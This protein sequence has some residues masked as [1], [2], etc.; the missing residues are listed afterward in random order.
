[1]K[2]TSYLESSMTDI[3]PRQTT[4]LTIA[5]DGPAASGKT[6]VGMRLAQAIGAICLDTGVMYRAVT[7]AVLQAGVDPLDEKAVVKVARKTKISVALSHM[8]DGR[9]FDVLVDSVDV[10]EQLRTDEVNRFVSEVSAYKGVRS[11]MTR[12][13][14]RIAKAGNIVMLGRDIGT[15][16]L[17]HADLKIY[18]NASAE[19]RAQRRFEEEKLRGVILDLDQV[20]ASIK[21][22]DVID[23][24]RKYAPLKPA[25]DAII[26]N[27]DGL[28]VEPVVALM[29][30]EVNKTLQKKQETRD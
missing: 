24:S 27:T 26:I 11:A 20:I 23:S 7:L 5:I 1:L 22:R 14:Q 3:I 9:P 21:H 17:P 8:E 16:V 25:A 30:D 10:T 19:T 6:T 2:N 28:S 4:G 12:Q 18:L 15:V 29:L 13:Q